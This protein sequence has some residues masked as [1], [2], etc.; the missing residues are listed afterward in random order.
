MK[1]YKRKKEK[2][3]IDL[4]GDKGGSLRIKKKKKIYSQESPEKVERI[5]TPRT[6]ELEAL[7]TT[8]SGEGAPSN[9]KRRGP[10]AQRTE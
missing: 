9:Y 3:E 5:I 8:R 4:R 1:D 6:K 2:G 7:E 10:A